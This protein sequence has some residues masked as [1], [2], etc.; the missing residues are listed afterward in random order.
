MIFVREKWPWMANVSGFDPLFVALKHS[1]REESKN[2]WIPNSVPTRSLARRLIGRVAKSEISPQS[3]SPFVGVR[4]EYAGRLLI[5]Q[6]CQD[7]NSYAVLSAGECQY[8]GILSY[9]NKEI[10]SRIVICFHQPPSWWRLNWGNFE[11]LEGLRAIVCLCR[12]QQ[13]YFAS[14]TSTPTILIKHGVEHKFFSPTTNQ[15][16]EYAPRLV[17]VGHWLRDLETLATA[18]DIIWKS[19]PKVELDCV[20][21][22]EGR[23][24]PA[25]FRLARNPQVKWHAKISEE[26]LR[27]VY[28]RATLLFC[29]LID[30][31]A[32][33]GILEALACGLPIISTKVGGVSEYVPEN[34]GQLCNQDSPEDHATAV[35][36]WLND[37]RRQEKARVACRQFAVKE[38]DWN[39][40]ATCFASVL[41]EICYSR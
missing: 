8:G 38:L 2:V 15:L 6:M 19:N 21:P 23:Q 22:H 25:L 40:I 3:P 5:Q 37:A 12:E 11:V 10:R 13:N 41:S 28:R 18:M 7:K 31:T 29:P 24:S 1:M 33:N 35:I 30:A 34:C 9:A 39:I 4:H 36:D 16:A 17:I 27:E 14:V 32:N 26:H 20:I